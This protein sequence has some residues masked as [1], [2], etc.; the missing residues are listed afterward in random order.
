[1]DLFATIESEQIPVD[2]PLPFLLTDFRQVR[3]TVLNDGLWLRPIDVAATLAARRYPV[4]IDTVLEVTDPLLGD[5]RLALAGGPDGA[6]CRPTDRPAQ[7]RLGVAELGSA[8]LGGHR[9]RTLARAG[10]VLCA[11]PGL[12]ARLDLAF[13]ADRAPFHGTAF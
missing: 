9:L 2:D 1:M 6:S 13:S 11:D 7:A 4:E 8:Y 12:L 3:T 10:A 5:R